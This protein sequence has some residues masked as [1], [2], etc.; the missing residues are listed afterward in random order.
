MAKLP[1]PVHEH[2]TSTAIVRWY[3]KR[4]ESPRPHLGA[5]LI[6]RPCDR[7]LWYTF[8]WATNKKFDGRLLRLFNT[9][10]REESRFIEELKG[11]GAEIYDRD[12]ETNTQHRFSAVRGHFG[13]SCDAIGRGLPEA[14]KTWAIIEFKTHN[15]DS[16]KELKAKGVALAKREHYVQ[17][18]IY[19]GLAE[20]ERALYLAVNK[21]TDELHSEWI[22]FDK[23]VFDTYM[24]RAEKI[25]DADVPPARLSEDPAWWQCKFCD[26]HAICHGERTANMNCR[27]CVHASPVDAGEW[28]CQKQERL[29]PYDEQQLGCRDHLYIPPLIK[30]AT[31]LDAGDNWIK[32]QHRDGVIFA[33]VTEDCEETP[34]DV[35]ARFTSKE[36]NITV[37]QFVS[38]PMTIGIKQD[39]PGSRISSTELSDDDECPF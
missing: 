27:T 18:Q 17:M 15:A 21:N 2:T 12:P 25:V 24:A 30:Y 6:G 23:A 3:E 34:E 5:S 11:I 13:G 38:D 14:P 8:R 4:K 22:H 26:H 31:P 39:F 7:E 33:N 19:M 37:A 16:F 28:G 1:D 9:G 36:L 20:L 29:L 10:H 32:Y 35:Q